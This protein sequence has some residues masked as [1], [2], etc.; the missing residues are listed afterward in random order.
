MV[1]KTNTREPNIIQILYL[2]YIQNTPNTPIPSSWCMRITNVQ[3]AQEMIILW[4]SQR[5]C[6]DICQLFMYKTSTNI[7]TDYL[8]SNEMTTYFNILGSFKGTPDSWI[9]RTL[10]DCHNKDE[11][12]SWMSLPSETICPSTISAHK[13]SLPWNGIWLM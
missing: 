8:V 12:E 4:F 2:P 11:F 1:S 9:C 6:E 5:L 7:P 10:L 13:L 3:L